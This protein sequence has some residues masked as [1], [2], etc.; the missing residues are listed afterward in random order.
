MADRLELVRSHPSQ[1]GRAIRLEHAEMEI[2]VW[3][4]TRPLQRKAVQHGRGL[5]TEDLPGSHSDP[6]RVTSRAEVL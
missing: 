2:R 1:L 4:G 6:E 5:M 3:S